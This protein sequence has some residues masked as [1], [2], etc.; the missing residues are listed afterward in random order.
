[1][2]HELVYLDDEVAEPGADLYWPVG[3]AVDQF[4]RDDLFAGELEHGQAG[5]VAHAGPAHL[6]V[7]ERGIEAERG[8]QVSDSVGGMERLHRYASSLLTEAGP[9][10]RSTGCRSGDP[11]CPTVPGWPTA[12]STI[13]PGAVFPLTVA[14]VCWVFRPDSWLAK[15]PDVSA[16]TACAGFHKLMATRSLT[17]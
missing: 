2:S 11:H 12:M 8:G 7:S 4:E 6:L 13:A 3:R 14:W 5:P 15:A 10:V 16:E 1:M 9:P 17:A